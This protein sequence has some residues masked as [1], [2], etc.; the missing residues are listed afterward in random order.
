[1]RVLLT[2]GTGFIGRALRDALGARGDDVVVVSRRADA[3][4]VAWS[5][6]ESEVGRADAIVHLAGEPVAAARWTVARLEKIRVSRVETTT[7][8][9]RAIERVRR[10][11]R[12]FVSASAIGIYGMRT[13]DERLDEKAPAGDDALARIVVA[14][15]AAARPSGPSAMAGTRV[16]H[17]R[18]GIVLGQGG[19]ALASMATPF[20]LFFGG[21]LGTG[22]QWLSW[23]HL[24]DAV[25]ALLFAIDT[26]AL[27][28]PANIVAPAPTIM[29]DFAAALGHALHR[30]A[31][32]RV[33]AVALR[34][35]LGGGLA[36]VLLT[37]Q[38][39]VPRRL[40][41]AGFAFEFPRLD[42]ALADI[43]R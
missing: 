24:R 18:F 2:G 22:K 14:W 38:R 28:G 9:A 29:D 32:L 1:M 30:P 42:D 23:I 8:L 12:V 40:L 6:I 11:P 25:R 36:G 43:Y 13:D 41:D 20:K 7:N 39:V 31:V 19:G 34:A 33:P 5:A 17:P 16:V 35:A 15:E 37:G 3:G 27:A 10:R 4:S 21:S 26:E